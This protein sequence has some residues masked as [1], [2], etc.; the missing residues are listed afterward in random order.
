MHGYRPSRG[1]TAYVPISAQSPPKRLTVLDAIRQALTLLARLPDSEQAH[2]LRDRCLAYEHV[3]EQWD[4]EPPSPDER[5]ILMKS[6]LS[7]QV[8]VAKLHRGSSV[9]SPIDRGSG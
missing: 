2:E 6:V 1:T 3:A 7:L 5:E 9:V 4:D 8:M